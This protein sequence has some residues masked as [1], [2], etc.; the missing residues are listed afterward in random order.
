VFGKARTLS[1]QYA[2]SFGSRDRA[3][4]VTLDGIDANETPA[5]SATFSPIR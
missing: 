1:R 2:R 4:N 5:G 3:F